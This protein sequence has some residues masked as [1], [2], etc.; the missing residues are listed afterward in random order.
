MFEINQLLMSV[1]NPHCIMNTQTIKIKYV[2]VKGDRNVINASSSKGEVGVCEW[3]RT[4]S[5]V[6]TV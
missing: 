6:P 2:E 4:S 1:T 3:V 5:K